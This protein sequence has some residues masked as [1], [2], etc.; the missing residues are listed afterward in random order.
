M[1]KLKYI[2]LDEDAEVNIVTEILGEWSGDTEDVKRYN[3]Q[4]SEK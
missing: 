4:D 1:E 2:V 3:L